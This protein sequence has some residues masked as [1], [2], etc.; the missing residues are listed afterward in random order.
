MRYIVDVRVSGDKKRTYKIDAKN[1]DEIH[2]RL[3]SRLAPKERESVIID[4][5][6]PDPAV[7]PSGDE[8]FGIFLNGDE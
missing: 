7:H 8:P 2:E 4:G 6:K 3:I 1:E 5:V